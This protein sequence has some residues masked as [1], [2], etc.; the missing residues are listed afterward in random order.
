MSRSI[1]LSPDFGNPEWLQILKFW[2]C[3]RSR[4]RA[5]VKTL[6]HLSIICWIVFT[7]HNRSSVHCFELSRQVDSENSH[8]AV[9]REEGSTSG[10]WD[11]IAND[12][13]CFPCRLFRE[14]L[15][16]M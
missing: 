12:F 3:R 5:G 11:A 9:C 14:V 1:V 13:C 8:P 15:L 4:A 16:N 7:L 6:V 10:E 2:R